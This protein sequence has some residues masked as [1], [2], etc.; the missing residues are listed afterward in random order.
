MSEIQEIS[1]LLIE[2]QC[3]PD[4]YSHGLFTQSRIKFIKYILIILYI[5]IGNILN[6]KLSFVILKEFINNY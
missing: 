3:S 4:P 2:L 6:L 1:A 5:I